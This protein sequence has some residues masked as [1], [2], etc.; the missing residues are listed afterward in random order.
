MKKLL[1]PLF[2]FLSFQLTAQT[3][4]LD[5]CIQYAID[6]NLTLQDLTLNIN[7]QQIAL[8]TAKNS[9]LPQISAHIGEDLSFDNMYASAGVMN[10][11]S[12]K[13]N[14]SYTSAS[15]NASMSL[16]DGFRVKNQ[17]E[18]DQFKLEAFTH[19]FEKAQKDISIQ[20]SVNY[21]QALY[22]QGLADISRQ[23][24]VLSEQ[25]LERAKK[26]VKE[27]R[28]PESEEANAA[29]Q[30]SNDQYQLA[31]DEGNASLALISLAQLLNLENPTGLQIADP[32]LSD[33]H[34][35]AILLPQAQ[36]VYNDC[37]DNFPSILAAKSNIQ[38][39]ER[40][41]K[42]AKTKYIPQLSLN[43]SLQSYYYHFFNNPGLAEAAFGKQLF[44]LNRSELVGFHLT[45]PIFNRCETRNNVR[46]AQVN[47]LK[48][49]IALEQE[50][51][52]LRVEIQQ[53]YYNAQVAASKY[54]AAIKAK[55]ACATSL[56][57]ERKS[58]DAGKSTL[59]DLNQANQKWVKAQQEEI[60]C[61]YEFLIRQKILEFYKK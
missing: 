50:R 24:V 12:N 48:E 28:R 30:L 23:Q 20:V 17:I 61:K 21:L 8:N 5:D 51:K 55:D 22:N 33:Q 25:L 47:I 52:K 41:L 43:A 6:H 16:L 3:F 39:A 11:N 35:Q 60:Q 4:S 53:A 1:I 56:D 54:Q 38:S 49:Q 10:T 46:I 57:Y 40:Q 42:V 7:Q 19:H 34:V 31:K 32:L 36:Q 14:V 26:L 59:F 13:I 9:W 2:V 15:I 58:Y 45:I 27:G 37:V 44:D 29:A 18:S